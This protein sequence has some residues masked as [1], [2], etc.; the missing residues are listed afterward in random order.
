M[1]NSLQTT[2]MKIRQLEKLGVDKVFL[3]DFNME[4]ARIN[5]SVFVREYLLKR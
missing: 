2:E 1:S 4:M 3:L 5:P